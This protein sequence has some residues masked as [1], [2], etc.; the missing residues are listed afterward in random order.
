MINVDGQ[1]IS[2]DKCKESIRAIYHLHVWKEKDF[3]N[4]NIVANV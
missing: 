3:D 4:E 1:F 2:D